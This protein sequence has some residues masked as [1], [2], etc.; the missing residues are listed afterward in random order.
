M[1]LV[2]GEKSHFS[3]FEVESLQFMELKKKKKPCDGVF[4]GCPLADGSMQW[5]AICLVPISA[6]HRWVVAA[7]L[8]PSAF[9]SGESLA[10]R[11]LI[12][13]SPSQI[14]TAQTEGGVQAFTPGIQGFGK[15][16]SQGKGRVGGSGEVGGG[17]D[18][19]RV[20][21]HRQMIYVEWDQKGGF[22]GR[23]VVFTVVCG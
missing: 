15:K 1:G 5:G 22:W 4:E 9:S 20:S 14:I 2:W 16:L 7:D 23:A 3:Q 17:L 6:L 21:F 13:R 8:S 11:G 18:A 10:G 19:W 12:W